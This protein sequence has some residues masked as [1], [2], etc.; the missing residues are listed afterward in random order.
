MLICGISSQTV[1]R[2]IGRKMTCGDLKRQLGVSQ[3]M[4]CGKFLKDAYTFFDNDIVHVVGKLRGGMEV[5]L[6]QLPDKVTRDF[7][8]FLWHCYPLCLCPRC[9]SLLLSLSCLVS[10]CKVVS[11]V[12]GNF[13]LFVFS[14]CVLARSRVSVTVRVRVKV[15]LTLPSLSLVCVMFSLFLY[16]FP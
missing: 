12:Q 16:R 4:S 11:M 5:N 13:P 14:L 2:S 9:L 6:D 8:T 15:S 10:L 3:L 7:T 1:I